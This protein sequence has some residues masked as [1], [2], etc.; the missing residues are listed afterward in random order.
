MLAK[1]RRPKAEEEAEVGA[2]QWAWG[3]G[4]R[5]RSGLDRIPP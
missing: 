2:R 3:A 1:M 4:Q 5:R